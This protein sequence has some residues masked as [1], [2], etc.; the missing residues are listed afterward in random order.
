MRVAIIAFNDL[1][2]CP[3]I[4]PYASFCK[5]NGI[6]FDVIYFN[7][8]GTVESAD[9]PTVPI[10][11]KSGRKKWLNFLSFRSLVIKHLKAVTYDFVIVLTTMPAVLLG[12]FLKKRFKG[13]YL[14]D[15]RDYTYEKILP[16]FWLEKRALSGS[17]MNVISSPGFK[18]FLPA[19]EYTLCHNASASYRIPA[20]YSFTPNPSGR[21]RIG[22]VGT[23]AYKSNCKRLIDLVLKDERFDFYFYGDE[24]GSKEVTEYVTSLSSDRIKAFGAYTPAE[25]VGIMENIDI[26]FNVYG[27]SSQ[28]VITALSNKLYDSFYM[29]LPLLTSPKTAMSEEASVYS[30]DVDFDDKDILEKLYSWYYSIDGESFGKYGDDYLDK[31]FKD[32]DD[33]YKKL[34]ATILGN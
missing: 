24:S 23:I 1:K 30:F 4:N 14:V 9:Y 34:K 28:L 26:L 31:V 7:R 15:I 17:A 33:F 20:E 29:K 3:Y 25:K 10:E 2:K 22:Y 27:N 32:Q 21:I 12:G 13:R 6:D 8:S 11:W 19:G 5:E 18:N 16:Y